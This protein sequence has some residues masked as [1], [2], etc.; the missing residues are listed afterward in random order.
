MDRTS[1]YNELGYIQSL[2]QTI[3]NGTVQEEFGYD[4]FDHL[5]KENAH[6]YRYDSNGNCL[7]KD[8]QLRSYN[9]HNQ[10]ISTDLDYD[11]KWKSHSKR[12]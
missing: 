9:D 7:E 5:T 1:H 10:S 8:T 11:A 3:P 4:R 12:K 6:T 2:E